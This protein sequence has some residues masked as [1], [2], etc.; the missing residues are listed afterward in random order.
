MSTVTL[1]PIDEELLPRVL[2]AAV[3]G[4]DPAEAMPPVPGPP[5]WTPERRAAFGDFHRTV[6]G[7]TYAVMTGGEV[8]G[9]TRLTPAE[10]PGAAEIGIWL[11]R[12]ARGK[13][14]GVEAL[15]LLIEEARARGTT[16]LIAETDAANAPAVGLLRTL[17]AKLWEDPDTGAVHATLR[18]GDSIEHGIGR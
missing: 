2:E 8:I 9:A 1:R 15:H 13:G 7:T 12:E 10:A 18:V 4:A 17:G 14:H 11:T 6:A 16:A 5:G 3:G